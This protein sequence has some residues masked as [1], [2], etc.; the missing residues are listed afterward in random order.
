MRSNIIVAHNAA[1]TRPSTLHYAWSN[2]TTMLA[3]M[4]CANGEWPAESCRKGRS[5]ESPFSQQLQADF[6]RLRPEVRT[7]A[8]WD[9]FSLSSSVALPLAIHRKAITPLSPFHFDTPRLATD[10]QAILQLLR[11]SF[12]L[13][14]RTSDGSSPNARRPPRAPGSRGRFMT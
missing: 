2:A 9:S 10:I 1:A 3:R 5:R 7:D 11:S 13:V 12:R 8:V 4:E 6:R 14:H